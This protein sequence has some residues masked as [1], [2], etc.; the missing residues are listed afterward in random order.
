MSDS[1]K[2][3]KSATLFGGAMNITDSLE[4]LETVEMGK[5]LAA[6]GYMVKNGGYGGMMEAVSKGASQE[7]AIVEGYTCATFG[8]H[9][10]NE[11]LTRELKRIDI[12]DRLR[13]LISDTDIFIAQKGGLG[14]LAEVFLTLDIIRKKPKSQRPIL[15][16]YGAFW[17]EVMVP[18]MNIPLVHDREKNLF[19]IIDTLE[20]FE[21]LIKM[22]E[23]QKIL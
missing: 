11:Y 16:L 19:I 5:L 20:D 10:G 2:I 13:S 12:Y 3:F 21:N 9:P 18:V 1:I 15:I 8:E 22:Y 17:T 6:N 4:Y 7:G 23:P 14:T